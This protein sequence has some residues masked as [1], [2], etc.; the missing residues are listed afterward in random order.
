M[1]VNDRR[2][3]LSQT[4]DPV[5]QA[6]RAI[7]NPTDVP[8]PSL[9]NLSL[10]QASKI[11]AGSKRNLSDAD[12]FRLFSVLAAVMMFVRCG[13]GSPTEPSPSSTPTPDARA[14]RLSP[15]REITSP[16]NGTKGV[17]MYHDWW[18][19]NET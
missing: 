5:V 19:K 4:L 15:P 10:R 7:E 13:G 1:H 11:A 6:V 17:L 9:N 8:I 2:T 3:F 18:A 14:N 12:A 16:Q